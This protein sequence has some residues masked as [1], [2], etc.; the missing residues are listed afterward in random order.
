[1]NSTAFNLDGKK[2]IVRGTLLSFVSIVV[3]L[4]ITAGIPILHQLN[5]PH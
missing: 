1:M 2:P 4:I 3:I 5:V